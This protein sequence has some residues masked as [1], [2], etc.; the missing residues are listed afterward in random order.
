MNSIIFVL[1][2][3]IYNGHAPT[4]EFKTMDKCVAAITVINKAVDNS[5]NTPVMKATCVRIEK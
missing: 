5:W 2:T 4:I 3:S 1:V